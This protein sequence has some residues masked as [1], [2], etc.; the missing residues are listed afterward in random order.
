MFQLYSIYLLLLRFA[1][2]LPKGNFIFT[3]STCLTSNKILNRLD[4]NT[5]QRPHAE[6]DRHPTSTLIRHQLELKA[7][8]AAGIELFPTW[9]FL[10]FRILY[11][12]SEGSGMKC[13]WM[14]D[15]PFCWSYK[16]CDGPSV[17]FCEV[18]CG[19][20]NHFGSSK[21][22]KRVYLG[23]LVTDSIVKKTCVTVECPNVTLIWYSRIPTSHFLKILV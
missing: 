16:A 6:L 19:E 7:D 5:S 14:R 12:P 10:N 17:H 4:K 3:E 8:M 13:C 9:G 15:D 2:F 1:L 11:L 21:C 18:G 23:W 22:V 20:S